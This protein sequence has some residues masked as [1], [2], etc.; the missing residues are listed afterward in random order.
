MQ[1]VMFT[2]EIGLT[3]RQRVMVPIVTLMVPTMMVNGSMISNTVM[4]KSH[5]PMVLDMKDI[6]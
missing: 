5:G 4:V 3:T 2:K 6:I 1:M